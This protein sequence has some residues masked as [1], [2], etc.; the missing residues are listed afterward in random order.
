MKKV[1]VFVFFIGLM[2]VSTST[3]W[4]VVTQ[5]SYKKGAGIAISPLNECGSQDLNNP[6]VLN[7]LQKFRSLGIT[8]LYNWGVGRNRWIDDN[9]EYV[10]MVFASGTGPNRAYT[11][12]ELSGFADFAKTH[13]GSYWLIW[14]EPDYYKQA[15]IPA[16]TAAAIYKPLRDAI[17]AADPTAKFIVGGFAWM[18]TAWINSFREEYKKIYNV[19]PP[20]DGWAFHHYMGTDYSSSLWRDRMNNLK[21]WL[22]DKGY[23]SKEFWLTEYGS[24]QSNAIGLRIM[25]DQQE[26]LEAPIQSWITRYAWFYLG[27]TEKDNFQGNLFTGDLTQNRIELSE[28]GREYAIH[29]VNPTYTPTPSP[30]TTPISL[31]FSTRLGGISSPGVTK[32]LEIT[33]QSASLTKSYTFTATSQ[34]NGLFSVSS[35]PLN[36]LTLGTFTVYIKDKTEGDYR[37]NHLRKSL[38]NITISSG[39]NSAPASWGT[40]SNFFLKPGDITGDNAVTIHDIGRMLSVYTQN[41]IAVTAANRINDIDGNNIINLTDILLAIGTYTN[42]RVTGD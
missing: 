27:I 12:S 7:F 18:D 10:P 16:G 6:C 15:N 4:A 1:L 38:G 24:L 30:T 23:Q 9:V 36:G 2:A 17:V 20:L 14:N 33:F 26:W 35:L 31:T 39:Q 21:R 8:W 11:A 37:T 34:T 13:P 28:L 19:Y 22:S 40:D 42:Y 5:K 25:Q 41:S 32:A 3:S 29:P